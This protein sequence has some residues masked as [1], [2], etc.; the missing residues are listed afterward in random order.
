[1]TIKIIILGSKHTGKASIANRLLHNQF[2]EVLDQRSKDAL[3]GAQYM[4]IEKAEVNAEHLHLF[5]VP[6]DKFRSYNSSYHRNATGYIVTADLSKD[7][8]IKDLSNWLGEIKMYS[9]QSNPVIWIVGTKSDIAANVDNSNK[10]ME[11]SRNNKASYIETSALQNHNMTELLQLVTQQPQSKA[12]FSR[13]FHH[14]ID[15]KPSRD[16]S[17]SIC[18]EDYYHYAD[19]LYCA[20]IRPLLFSTNPSSNV[21]EIE[22]DKSNLHKFDSWI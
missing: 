4:K 1:M 16:T 13:D 3:A 17:K 11:F 18:D 2:K 9:Q 15:F 21:D 10:L 14:Y 6:T 20:N 12:A 8:D 19:R 5:Y 22:H 7:I